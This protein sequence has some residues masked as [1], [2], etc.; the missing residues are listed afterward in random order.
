VEQFPLE[1]ELQ[2]DPAE[3]T[4]FSPLFMPKAE[5]FFCT[6]VLSHFVHLTFSLLENTSCSK[7]LPQSIHSYSYIG[8]D[9]PP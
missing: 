3:E 6:F 2:A 9:Y 4:N 5:S 1:Q 7:L 8:I